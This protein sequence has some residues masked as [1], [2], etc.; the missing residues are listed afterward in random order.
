MAYLRNLQT[1]EK[2]HLL[3]HHTFGRRS[4]SV[5]T[6]IDQPEISKIHA[7]I[8]WNSQSWEIRDLGRNGTWLD[9]QKL[10]AAKN[11]QLR[12]GQIINFSNQKNNSWKVENTDAPANLL[13]GLN[14][15]SITEQLSH[16]HLL[17]NSTAPIAA[18]FFCDTRG[19]WILES[20][21]DDYINDSCNET[22]ISHNSHIAIG[23]Y[24][25][26]LFLNAEQQPTLDIIDQQS[27]IDQ[28]AF[29]FDVSLDE[30]HTQL[31][32]GHQYETIDLGERSHHYLLLHLARLKAE[33]ANQGVDNKSQGWINNE[34]LA[35]ELGIDVSHINIQIFRARKQIADEFPGAT[36]LLQR[37]RGEVRFNCSKA[38]IS[39]GDRV[40]SLSY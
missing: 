19:E 33:H 10:P 22:I 30:E 9:Q 31:K 34:Q 24:K 13:L 16:Y 8:E 25:W 36:D 21:T 6:F 18:I 28:V 32:L 17:P 35:K 11:I 23:D 40:E 15:C 4:D 12:T 14:N 29:H 20:N 7:V 27:S 38:S 1:N 5:D 2:L 3:S 39:K 37:R 26:K